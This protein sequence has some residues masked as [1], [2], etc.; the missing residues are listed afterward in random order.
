MTSQG[1]EVRAGESDPGPNQGPGGGSGP[2]R[3]SVGPTRSSASIR[4]RACIQLASVAVAIVAVTAHV[5][6]GAKPGSPATATTVSTSP[7]APEP[8]PAAEGGSSELVDTADETPQP[9]AAAPAPA[10][11]QPPPGPDPVKVAAG[12][13]ALDA[14][15]GDRA[16]ADG[17]SA[18]AARL[19][20]RA[21]DQAALDA[22]RARKLAFQVRDPSNRIAQA[23]VRGGFVRGEREKLAKEVA[24]LR[25]A[26]RPKSVSILSKSP[27][28]R[29][30]VD[31]E[32]HFELRHGRIAFIDL[33]KLLSITKSDAEMRMRMTDRVGVISNKVGPVG[34]FSLAYELAP[35]VPADLDGLIERRRVRH[36]ELQ[37]WELVPESDLRGETYEATRNPISEFT[38]ALNRINRERATITLWTYPDSFGLYRRIRA[39]LLDRGYSVAARPLPAGLGIRG[40]PLGSQ[41]AAQ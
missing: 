33:A 25:S 26:P 40:S 13:Q 15:S 3:P 1:G 34:A 28:A 21:A 4:W 10:P 20:A 31:D 22:L 35:T 27:V 23:V 7:A 14:A 16:R 2:E 36:Y 30:V 5:Q 41:S 38:R 32:Y 6:F 18:D 29:P 8:P 11:A 24:T 17:R 9:T 19:M 37:S 12:E 39:D